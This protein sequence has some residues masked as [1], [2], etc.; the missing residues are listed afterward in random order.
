MSTNKD[1]LGTSLGRLMA[2]RDPSLLA[3]LAGLL[4]GSI[5]WS[6][7]V[8]APGVDVETGNPIPNGATEA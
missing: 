6:D 2:D 5:Q 8:D 1:E 7:I 3:D 4:D